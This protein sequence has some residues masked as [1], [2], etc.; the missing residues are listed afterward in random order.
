MSYLDLREELVRR[1]REDQEL[2]RKKAWTMLEKVYDQ[3]ALWLK[4]VVNTLGWPDKQKVGDEGEQS[5]W[6]IAQHASD[7]DFQER[8]LHYLQHLPQTRERLEYI[9]YLT[10]RILVQKGEQQIYGTQFHHREPSPIVDQKNL[11]KRRQQIGL[12]LFKEYYQRM[13][14]L[15]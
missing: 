8:C 7:I 9:A 4:N 3:N 11:D 6:L 14:Q 13:K 2:S 10:D 1:F 15:A 5:A 12:E